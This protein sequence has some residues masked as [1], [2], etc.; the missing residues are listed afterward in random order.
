MWFWHPL[1]E[2]IENYVEAKE[3]EFVEKENRNPRLYTKDWLQR[4]FF[5]DLLEIFF[6]TFLSKLHAWLSGLA[7]RET[8]T[9]SDK[10]TKWTLELIQRLE[11]TDN[12]ISYAVDF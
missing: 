3:K 11:Q 6:A 9:H 12:S 2:E 8:S 4:Y 1:K 10:P 7:N 5:T